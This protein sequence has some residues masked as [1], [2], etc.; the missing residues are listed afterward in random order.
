[1]KRQPP[2]KLSR[3]E[4]DA[5]YD[6]LSPEL[7]EIAREYHVKQVYQAIHM[8]DGSKDPVEIKNLLDYNRK[9]VQEAEQIQNDGLGNRVIDSFKKKLKL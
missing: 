4:E 8:L 5:F 9:L 6:N 2:P 1:M 7:R 3:R